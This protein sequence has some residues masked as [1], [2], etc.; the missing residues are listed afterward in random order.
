MGE[1]SPTPIIAAVICASGA[2]S[3]EAP[4]EPCAGTTGMTSLAEHGLEQLDR[5]R[6][7]AGGACARLASFSAIIRRDDRRR[8]RLADAGGNARGRCC[9]AGLR[10]RPSAMRTLASLP[11][12][13]L[14]P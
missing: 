13:V 4:T 6:P 9:A 14:M 12:P 5:L 7:H 11:K 8:H 2:R 3:P 10:D 1:A